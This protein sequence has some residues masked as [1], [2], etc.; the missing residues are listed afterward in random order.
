MAI[1]RSLIPQQISKGGKKMPKVG[2]KHFKYTKEGR[3]KA[4]KHA[5]KTGLEIE[6]MGGGVVNRKYYAMG[7]RIQE[8]RK[9]RKEK[10]ARKPG[11]VAAKR[12][13]L[14]GLA[15]FGLAGAGAGRA[16]A[17]PGTMREY[18][19]KL[20]QDPSRA[21]TVGKL[22]A[23]AAQDALRQAEMGRLIGELSRT[24]R[25]ASKKTTRKKVG[26]DWHKKGKKYASGGAVYGAARKRKPK[27]RLSMD[28]ITRA[29]RAGGTGGMKSA[30]QKAFERA[31]KPR[32]PKGRLNIDDIK[33]ALGASKAQ[34]KAKGGIIGKMRKGAAWLKA[35]RGKK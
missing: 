19:R 14:L 2:K 34:N 23:Q 33:R 24:G 22:R 31:H 25:A 18:K 8:M 13:A 21:G 28:D 5:K 26:P 9:K 12:A 27:G 15:Q 16:G 32:K 1:S 29:A 4:K 10:K 30:L 7:G 3:E 17:T 11:P 20:G 6:Y 35:K